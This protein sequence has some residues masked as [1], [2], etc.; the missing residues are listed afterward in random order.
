MRGEAG[1]TLDYRD[2]QAKLDLDGALDGK[3]A[4]LDR[5]TLAKTHMWATSLDGAVL[6]TT[7]QDV[8]LADAR[9]A[10]I[11]AHGAIRAEPVLVE[12]APALA[13]FRPPASA[14]PAR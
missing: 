11:V 2:A 4:V 12:G 1:L 9:Y 13:M 10:E 3:P 8:A 7:P 5:T 6:V 14:A